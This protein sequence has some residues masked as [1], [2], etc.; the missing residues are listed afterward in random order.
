MTAYSSPSRNP[1][2]GD[3]AARLDLKELK[4]RVNLRDIVRQSWGQ[5]KRQTA[6]RDTY[7]SHWR[8]D[9]AKASFVVNETGFKDFGGTGES[10][11]VFAFIQRE[12]N[13]TFV[14][15]VD[16]LIDYTHSRP[17]NI[18]PRPRMER[19]AA[20]AAPAANW[21]YA[22][23]SFTEYA[24]RQLQRA[25][26]I[27][28]YLHIDRLLT[29]E[30][31]KAAG[32]GYNPQAHKVNGQFWA[33]AGITIPRY[34]A[35]SLRLVN[36]RTVTGA[37]AGALGVEDYKRFNGDDLD[38]Y[39]CMAGSKLIG[40]LYYV[41]EP[42]PGRPTVFFEGEFDCI[43]AWQEFG[44]TINAVTLGGATNRITPEWKNRVLALNSPIYIALDSDGAGQDATKHLINELGEQ[45]R[46]IKYPAG[47]KD[48]TD[49]VNAGMDARTWFEAQTSRYYFAEGAP[50]SWVS[51]I[52]NYM[53]PGAALLFVAMQDA[54]RKGGITPKSFTAPDLLKWMNSNG[55][56]VAQKTFYRYLEAVA[57]E[58]LSKCPTLSGNP[59]AIKD[60][61]GQNDNKC[62]TN[63]PA[64]HY[65]MIELSEIRK[66]IISQAKSRLYDREFSTDG[67][68]GTKARPRIAG[69]TRLGFSPAFAQ[70]VADG[71]NKAYEPIYRRQS[72][73]YEFAERRIDK[74]CGAL[75]AG[76]TDLIPLKTEGH[77]I[78]TQSDLEPCLIEALLK[79][80]TPTSQKRIASWLGKD[81][82]RV[83]Q[84]L[85]RSGY[86]GA[87]SKVRV[88]QV[89]PGQNIKKAAY[90]ADPEARWVGVYV[91]D[92][93]EIQPFEQSSARKATKSLA[94]VIQPAY[95]YTFVGK[96]E[97]GEQPAPKPKD[98]KV[99]TP[100]SKAAPEYKPAPYWGDDVNP[101]VDYNQLVLGLTLSDWMY[102]QDAGFWIDPT[103]ER[104]C[105]LLKEA[106]QIQAGILFPL[107]DEFAD[108]DF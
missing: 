1:K 103:G 42:V 27:L 17:M 78:K 92:N 61:V 19:P 75:K 108:V 48:F 88:I 102:D 24:Q 62:L 99:D 28:D 84:I 95:T 107:Q 79:E 104:Y 25:Q 38:K 45:A 31:I 12:F 29:D 11:D 18:A 16:W 35:D 71:L 90:E 66:R 22:G 89:R 53:R 6:D 106:I 65:C 83:G 40:S 43:L 54:A 64:V 3:L 85:A 105:R 69:L 36:I 30:T 86:Q 81:R 26:P 9:G 100:Q 2:S 70:T 4:S 47:Y 67:K 73:A 98:K 87:P 23:I 33:E 44:D 15:A 56:A 7:F 52:K 32:L 59:I 5:P 80:G 82:R 55:Y 14:E 34:H 39:M 57:G 20:S 77:L 21:Q 50:A 58:L 72:R 46:G 41:T 13:L 60:H 101:E 94:L 96:P 97:P 49:C 91:D 10:G 37:F 93:P 8:P 76:L 63:R 51:A 68:K 74:K